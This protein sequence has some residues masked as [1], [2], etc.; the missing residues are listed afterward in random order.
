VTAVVAAGAVAA[1][2]VAA[3]AVATGAVA[4]AVVT[5]TARA[6]A[7]AVARGQLHDTTAGLGEHGDG[8]GGDVVVPH[9]VIL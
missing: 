1:T 5:S 2:V 7:V 4:V 9:P 6:A 8:D 3:V